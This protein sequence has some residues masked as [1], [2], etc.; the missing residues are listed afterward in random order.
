VI[1]QRTKGEGGNYQYMRARYYDPTTGRFISEDPAGLDAG[2]NLYTYVGGNP[3][4]RVDP[5]GLTGLS[6]ALIFRNLQ[7]NDQAANFF[8][9]L[10]RQATLA[11]VLS[12]AALQ[13]EGVL[14]FGAIGTGA[15][16][17]EQIIRPNLGATAVGSAVSV[18]TDQLPGR[19]GGPVG[20]AIDEA[21]RLQTPN[22]RP[23]FITLG[24]GGANPDLLS[25]GCQIKCF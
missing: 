2:V 23:P 4:S 5:S 6:T 17:F 16:A 25:T 18:F 3:I 15:A 20:I 9:E 24:S 7:G 1:E 14:L 10:N 22:A 21:R 8:G 11:T 19:V 13:P 12:G